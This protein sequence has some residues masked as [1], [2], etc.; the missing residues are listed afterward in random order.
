MYMYV[1]FLF[2]KPG[3]CYWS[4]P[5]GH[6]GMGA[7]DRVAGMC[8]W[9]QPSGIHHCRG[10]VCLYSLPLPF[11]GRALAML[12]CTQGTL[13]ECVY[14]SVFTEVWG[15]GEGEGEGGRVGKQT[16]EAGQLWPVDTKVVFLL[17]FL[18]VSRTQVGGYVN[19]S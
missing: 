11:A 1:H 15:G 3:L 16:T 18:S 19:Q 7:L 14:K 13:R 10:S 5:P 17:I 9:P 6:S 2:L 12:S 8:S 4:V